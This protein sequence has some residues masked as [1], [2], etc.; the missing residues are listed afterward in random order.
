M[1]RLFLRTLPLLIVVP[2][3][4]APPRAANQPPARRARPALETAPHI[5]IVQLEHADAREAARMLATVA[6]V[7]GTQQTFVPGL[8][9][10]TP[11]PAN[12]LLITGTP[13]AIQRV[14]GLVRE[15][16]ELAARRPAR[17]KPESR[18][19]VIRSVRLDSADAAEV[20]RVLWQLFPG[21]EPRS[22]RRGTTRIVP[23]RATNELWVR[24]DPAFV[25]Q[26]LELARRLDE[27]FAETIRKDQ[28]QAL[29][30]QAY[31]LEHA[32]ATQ[33]AAMIGQVLSAAGSQARIMTDER[34]NRVLIAGSQR[35]QRIVQA[36]LKV[37]D[38][39]AATESS[40]R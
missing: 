28:S 27:S 21:T 18:E 36:L 22:D 40:E 17:S 19:P 34:T 35:D 25:E 31:A 30:L 1:S 12:T 5:A 15:L 13:E 8:R 23:R 38:V 32:E 29:P 3:F 11:G 37:I 24:G 20:A 10:V 16:D 39:P 33:A 14:R 9:R 7:T 2:C 4:A 6:P 26:A